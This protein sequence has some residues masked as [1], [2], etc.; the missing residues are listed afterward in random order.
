MPLLLDVVYSTTVA[1]QGVHYTLL[2]LCTL[3]AQ[4]GVLYQYSVHCMLS[5]EYSADTL[6]TACSARSTLSI[7]CTLHAQ[8]GVLY[9]Y[10]AGG[11]CVSRCDLQCHY[12]V[13][14]CLAIPVS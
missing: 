5:K 6:Y 8:Q 12:D 4:Q 11:D 14:D 13:S 7:L 9:R 1:Q 2:I 10:S 3:H